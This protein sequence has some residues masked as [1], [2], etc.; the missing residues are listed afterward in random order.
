MCHTKY[1]YTN[2]N[3]YSNTKISA[4]SDNIYTVP[5][6]PVNKLIKKW[7]IDK[8]EPAANNLYIWWVCILVMILE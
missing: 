2:H 8:S 6:L 7:W 3:G 4:K 1:I 5:V